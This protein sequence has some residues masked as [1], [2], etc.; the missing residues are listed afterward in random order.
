[1]IQILLD[2]SGRKIITTGTLATSP[3]AVHRTYCR[4]A[5]S[6]ALGKF[7]TLRYLKEDT[8]VPNR[9]FRIIIKPSKILSKVTVRI[10]SPCRRLPIVYS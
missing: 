7:R 10:L 6:G 9:R 5:I 1:M 2:D 4:G 3:K 8:K